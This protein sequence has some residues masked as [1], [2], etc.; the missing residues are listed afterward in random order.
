MRLRYEKCM[1][2][3]VFKEP[4]Q[5]INER[6]ILIDMIIKSMQNSVINIYKD[7]KNNAMSVIAKL[8]ALSPLKTLTRGYSIVGINEK[9]IKSASELKKDD[10]VDI[11]FY[12]GKA[13]AKI[14]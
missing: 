14:M 2:G 13:K 7:K 6:Y 5:K 11:R 3:R 8:D 9:V 12:D 10:E 4:F 1:S